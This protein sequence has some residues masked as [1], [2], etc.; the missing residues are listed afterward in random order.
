MTWQEVVTL[1]LG[2]ILIEN[3]VL[4]RF[5]GVCPFLGVSKKTDTALG[6][7]LSVIFVMTAAAAASWAIRQY[8]LIPFD[9][10]HLSTIA[11]ILVI[12]AMVQ[13]AEITLKK[14]APELFTRLGIY[15]PLIAANCA[16]LG[17][18][19][20][21]RDSGNGFIESVLFA[22]MSGVGFSL[23]LLLFSSIRARLEFSEHPEA[24]EGFPIALITAGLLALA[25]TG[26]AGMRIF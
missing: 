2:A 19:L 22:F 20:I 12:A 4:T 1:S 13:F 18:A 16:V 26:F 11:F 23:A 9:V 24:F 7:S 21:I 25:F 5:L 3:F 17:V 6:M 14:H 10:E 15:L 8:L